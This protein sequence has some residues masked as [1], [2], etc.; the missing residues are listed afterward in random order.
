MLWNLYKDIYLYSGVQKE[1]LG[2]KKYRYFT[3]N[4]V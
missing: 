4:V 1:I 2:L 3:L